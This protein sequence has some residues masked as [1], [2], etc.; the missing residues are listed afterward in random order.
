MKRQTNGGKNDPSKKDKEFIIVSP[1]AFLVDSNLSVENLRV[2]AQTRATHLEKNGKKDPH[3]LE[4]Y[5]RLLGLEKYLDGEIGNLIEKH[6]VWPW[7]SQVKGVGLEN[8]PKIVGLIDIKKAKTISG[9]WKF[10]GYD[11]QNG[12]GPK[13][14][15]GKKLSYNSTLRSMC[16]RMGGSLMKAGGSFYG[17][18]L[19]EKEKYEARFRKEGRKIVKA[20]KLPVKNGKRYESKGVIS[21]G[22]I[23][24][25]ALRKM[26]KLFLACL[27]VSWREGL[28]LP[29]RP[30][31]PIDKLGHSH[32]IRPEDMV[33][34][35]S[36]APKKEVAVGV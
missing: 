32:I 20:E 17:Y 18:Y 36:K 22:H 33:D 6:P 34:R 4:I 29:T 23:H 31:Y 21:E 26:I 14:E 8:L 2:G 5:D 9:L 25:M 13:R 35:E 24:N 16:W 15:A 19:K 7:A 10:A 1:F 27:W 11:V 12:K 28:G 30:P 3:T